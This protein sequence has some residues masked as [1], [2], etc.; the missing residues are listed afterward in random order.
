MKEVKSL[1]SKL[2]FMKVWEII[3]RQLILSKNKDW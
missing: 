1:F 3:K 2:E